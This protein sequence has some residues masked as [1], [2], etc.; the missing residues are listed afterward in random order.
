[1]GGEGAIAHEL[2]SLRSIFRQT[3][4]GQKRHDIYVSACHRPRVPGGVSLYL[5]TRLRS[6][7]LTTCT[8]TPLHLIT[9]SFF[10]EGLIYWRSRSLTGN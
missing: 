3:M 8:F 10:P 7:G 2:G 4:G 5:A 6:H 9:Y 1:M